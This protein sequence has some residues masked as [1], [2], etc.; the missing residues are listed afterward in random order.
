MYSIKALVYLLGLSLLRS[1]FVKVLILSFLSFLPIV[2]CLIVASNSRLLTWYTL[3]SSLDSPRS[4]LFP[5][6]LFYF[7]SSSCIPLSLSRTFVLNSVITATFLYTSRCSITFQ[8]LS[9]VWISILLIRRLWI[10][11]RYRRTS[12]CYLL[13][14][15]EAC[16]LAILS[17]LMCSYRWNW[18]SIR[19][20]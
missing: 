6:Y 17:F 11:P 7:K 1:V 5:I 16:S 3:S 13:P 8:A 9:R 10:T 15:W 4:S 20:I 2:I 18:C 12:Y 14:C 19:S